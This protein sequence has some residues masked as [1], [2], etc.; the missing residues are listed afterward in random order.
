MALLIAVPAAS[1]EG[2]A[3]ASGSYSGNVLVAGDVVL[4][5]DVRIES[6]TDVLVA[7]GASVDISRFSLTI[8]QGS[9][10][11]VAGSASIVS[12]GGSIVLEGGLPLSLGTLSL[13]RS[14]DDAV[15]R[16][17]GTVS[18]S[19]RI[20]E[21]ALD[22]GFKPSGD[23]GW[24]RVEHGDTT[25]S[26][27][28]PSLAV[29]TWLGGTDLTAGFSRMA[30][31]EETWEGN[32]LV[33][34]RTTT[35]VSDDSRRA[36]EL[37]IY[38]E[39]GEHGH[40]YPKAFSISSVRTSASY[41]E[42]GAVRTIEMSG[43]HRPVVSLDGE[44]VFS[45]S[46]VIDEA[47]SERL[48]D[49]RL[50]SR[51]VCEEIGWKASFDL[52]VLIEAIHAALSHS[53]GKVG[54]SDVV[55]GVSVTVDSIGIEDFEKG[56]EK[57]LSDFSAR[58]SR[59]VPA[60][61]HTVVEWRDEGS[62][63]RVSSS[64]I[65]VNDLYIGRGFS[66][67]LG[68][69]V[70]DLEARMDPAEG[71][72]IR[73]SAS[74]LGFD[75]S[76]MELGKLHSVY[77]RTGSLDIQQ[78]LDCCRLLHAS[79][80]SVIYDEGGR[81]MA[82]DGS[83]LVLQKDARR[84]STLTLGICGL[85][86]S[87]VVRDGAVL[88][89]DIGP[90]SVYL[91]TDGSLA[92]YI[93]AL[94]S[95]P[96]L[97][98]DSELV[99]QAETEGIRT[100][101]EEAGR[102]L[103]VS[104]KR[105]SSASP[106]IELDLSLRHAVYKDVTLVSG[107]VRASGYEIAAKELDPGKGMLLDAVMQ[108]PEMAIDGLDLGRLA[109]VREET[110]GIGATD[111]A[112][113]AD[114]IVLRTGAADVRYG[115]ARI[116]LGS[117]DLRTGASARYT[118][119]LESG[120]VSAS[121]PAGGGVLD[122]EAASASASLVSDRSFTEMQKASADGF[123]F[124]SDVSVSLEAS[125]AGADARLASDSIAVSVRGDRSSVVEAEISFERS[126][127]WSLSDLDARLSA[128]GC[129]IDASGKDGGVPYKASAADP[130][131]V[132]EDVDVDALLALERER[133]SI[134]AA[135]ILDST[136]G[137][138]VSASSM[139]IDRGED[140]RIEA[141]GP[142]LSIGTEGGS[143]LRFESG[144]LK[145]SASADG[146][147]L[148]V[149]ASSM[150][151][152]A[153][154][155]ATFEQTIRALEGNPGSD[156]DM[157]LDLSASGLR[158]E[159]SDDATAVVLVAN[160]GSGSQVLTASATLAHS[161]EDF[162][163][164]LG[165]GVNAKGYRLDLDSEGSGPDSQPT[166]GGRIHIMSTDP[167]IDVSGLDIGAILEIYD[168]TGKVE[169]QQILDRCESLS[170]SASHAEVEWDGDGVADAVADGARTAL[171]R[172]AGGSA[173]LT[174][175]AEKADASV[176]ADEVSVDLHSASTE[177][178]FSSDIP[179]SE[180]LELVADGMRFTDDTNMAV[181]VASKG[182]DVMMERDDVSASL[183]FSPL[184]GPSEAVV[185]MDLDLAYS[186]DAGSTSLGGKLS[187]HGFRTSLS[188]SS[189]KGSEG[190]LLDMPFSIGKGSVLTASMDDLV[191]DMS[192]FDAAAAYRILEESGTITIQQL[193]DCGD[194][195]GAGAS[196]LSVDKEGDGV[197][198]LA[199]TGPQASL[200]KNKG[201]N[202]ISIGFDSLETSAALDPGVIGV[203]SAA[204]DI[205]IISEGSLSECIGALLYGVDFSAET[206]AE[207]QISNES[208][209]IEY[210]AGEDRVSISNEKL[211]PTSP[212]SVT[213]VLSLR[214][215]EYDDTTSLVGRLSSIGHSIVVKDRTAVNEK[216]GML[217]L[218]LRTDEVSGGFELDYG[219]SVG[220]SANLYM[221]WTM[222]YRYYDVSFRLDS[223]DSV[224]S[225]TRGDLA[226]DGYDHREQGLLALF[227]ALKNDDF[228][229]DCRV[230][231][232]S[233]SLDVYGKDESVLLDSYGEAEV[234]VKKVHVDL[235]RGDVLNV[236][237]EKVGL[238]ITDEDGKVT[239]RS[240]ER[241]DV[242]KDESGVEPEK[243]WAER[244]ALALAVVFMA[245][246]AAMAGYLVHRHV[247]SRRKD[248]E[249]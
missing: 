118:A 205:T 247:A 248:S 89:L 119:S 47:V 33:N 20:L 199:A 95:V 196:S 147:R 83:D 110:G 39:P 180:L 175:F 159:Y 7:N 5:G 179:F 48:E 11:I 44:G 94:S 208:V 131:V 18:F 105:N 13:P 187:A 134:T 50:V 145:A 197:I 230:L 188:V 102:E 120:S 73:I 117:L 154:S 37:A 165:A 224:V 195:L 25:V 200:G 235:R 152:A 68:L 10:V 62:H 69:F 136:A 214:Y 54:I 30:V 240:L 182:M 213:A 193:L 215:S 100:S 122:L 113:S 222:D 49:G 84:H 162:R 172:S 51:T 233:E 149:E 181:A 91:S 245:A 167:E 158:L 90:S 194:R 203:R 80:G 96:K 103:S 19:L 86:G 231:M 204:S 234:D 74:D 78:V 169:V 106:G 53:D 64:R 32:I 226:V 2:D 36:L 67:D 183:A 70:S 166:D 243:S 186:A 97:T 87:A 141:E 156:V 163:T 126:E 55:K 52:V 177:V 22:V 137:A 238:S 148:E 85:K 237:L 121:I 185:R 65:V 116:G 190:S 161:A 140:L 40:L 92:E 46:S 9:T 142:V 221:P 201:Q 128:R 82:A 63:F 227:P 75:A 12:S 241:L 206:N 42:S 34:S 38:R 45:I 41:V 111:L 57:N 23:D 130:V 189:E 4:D 192:G 29:R 146:G 129:T 246:S 124:D 6:G 209:L 184:D 176:P 198:D 160:R 107:S 217:D 66:V 216:G 61:Y 139:C 157:G 207:L 138:S 223:G 115:E 220:F 173:A 14:E 219:K 1:D 229:S 249:E 58:V 108:D 174:L 114:R 72:S 43:F 104:S 21:G 16:F 24:V 144:G 178:S 77:E 56:T 170:L 191:L 71:P 211:S 133:G 76:D 60:Q 93:D 202:T 228:R 212:R 236:V 225:I 171:A 135:D 59:D 81:A 17:D 123:S 153:R 239:E 27:E 155:D 244:N 132:L 143:T 125:L 127:R 109:S 99:L 150:S 101:Y 151:A 79:A 164:L 31:E 26:V 218:V 232:S 8:G 112:D 35:I 98:S 88:D 242:T 3:G 15:V 28:H 210:S 168:R